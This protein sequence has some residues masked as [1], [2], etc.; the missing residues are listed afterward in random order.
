MSRSLL[1]S[2]FWKGFDGWVDRQSQ[3]IEGAGMC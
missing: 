1:G 2:K 3:V